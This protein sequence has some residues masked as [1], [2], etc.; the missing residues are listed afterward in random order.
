MFNPERWL[1]SGIKTS[2]SVGV[3]GNLMTFSSGIRAVIHGLTDEFTCTL[4][5]CS[6]FRAENCTPTTNSWKFA[7]AE[8][9]AFLFEI[10]GQMEF[11]TT[12]ELKRVR[13]EAAL[14]MVPTIEGELEKGAQMP[15]RVR[16]AP[17]DNE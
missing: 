3:I 4:A 17:Q 1:N 12:P 2:T 11:S 8:L 13:R 16:V 6:L 10:V 15:L 14:V 5:Y 9:Q 7:F